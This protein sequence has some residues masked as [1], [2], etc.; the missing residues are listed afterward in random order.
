MNFRDYDDRLLALPS[1]LEV[2]RVLS[3]E[4]NYITSVSRQVNA[5][6]LSFVIE[7]KVIVTAYRQYN[8]TKMLLINFTA[9]L[10]FVKAAYLLDLLFRLSALQP[11]SFQK[12]W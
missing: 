12:F 10:T 2:Y 11:I 1:D 4:N 7:K 9:C 5:L 8:V 6:V 3:E